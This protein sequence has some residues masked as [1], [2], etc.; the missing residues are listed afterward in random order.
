MRE[1]G[2]GEID[3]VPP[4][5]EHW[6]GAAPEQHLLQLGLVPLGGGIE[7]LEPVS[8]AQYNGAAR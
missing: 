8:D 1:L 7:F 6:H 3:Y 4:G 2:P 5:V